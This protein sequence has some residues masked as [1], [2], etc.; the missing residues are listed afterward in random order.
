[1][2]IRIVVTTEN[3][4]E[5]VYR[6]YVQFMSDVSS[7]VTLYATAS[8]KSRV[9]SIFNRLLPSDSTHI[10]GGISYDREDDEARRLWN[11]LIRFGFKSNILAY[12]IE[13]YDPI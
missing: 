13:T 8:T 6:F 5:Q 10:N 2:S 7:N 3:E 4:I 12:D 9:K 1:M 11:D